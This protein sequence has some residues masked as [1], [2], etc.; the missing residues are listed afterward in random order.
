MSAS[1]RRYWCRERRPQWRHWSWLSTWRPSL[2]DPVTTDVFETYD[3]EG[4]KRD[5]G[6]LRS[7]EAMCA[8]VNPTRTIRS[9]SRRSGLI[10]KWIHWKLG[11]S[12]WKRGPSG[13][14]TPSI[15]DT[16][17]LLRVAEIEEHVSTWRETRAEEAKDQAIH[18]FNSFLQMW[19]WRTL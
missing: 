18:G 6:H 5:K 11:S 7:E 16:S 3:V 19:E 9:R 8:C 13:H 15:K 1:A 14:T 2:N 17:P 12:R 10:E 4:R